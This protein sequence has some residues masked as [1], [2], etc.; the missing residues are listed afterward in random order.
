INLSE[1]SVDH[2]ISEQ[3]QGWRLLMMLGAVPALLTFLIRWFVPESA[4]WERERDK[5][6]TSHWATRDLTSVLIGACAACGI[7]V[8]WAIDVPLA[9]RIVGSL[10]GFAIVTWGYTFPVL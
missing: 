1:S 6:A 9:V 4:K 3:N 8:L 2:L 10:V 7:I 5:G